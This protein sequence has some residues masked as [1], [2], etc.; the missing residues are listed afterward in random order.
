[1]EGTGPTPRCP[2]KGTLRASSSP[3]AEHS[4]RLPWTRWVRLRKAG[5]GQK[6]FQAQCSSA[7]VPTSVP[8]TGQGEL[9]GPQTA[10]KV[11]DYASVSH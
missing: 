9:L 6:M 5:M 2:L 4:S 1:M 8:G 11:G 7:Y 3:R 10:Q